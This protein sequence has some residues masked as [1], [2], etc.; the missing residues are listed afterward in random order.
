MLQFPAHLHSHIV[1][2]TIWKMKATPHIL[3]FMWPA[4]LALFLQERICL[5]DISPW[6]SY[7]QFT[8]NLC[9]RVKGIWFGTALNYRRLNEDVSSLDH[10]FSYEISRR[11]RGEN[12][13]T[14]LSLAGITCWD[15]W[16]AKLLRVQELLILTLPMWYGALQFIILLRWSLK[17]PGVLLHWRQGWGLLFITG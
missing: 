10:W 6:I 8:W 15:I 4:F 14:F 12:L 3:N 5:E 11:T 13:D 7:V 17:G 2:S 9:P 1:D 16:K